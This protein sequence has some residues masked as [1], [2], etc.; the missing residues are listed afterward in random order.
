MPRG[1][2]NKPTGPGLWVYIHPICIMSEDSANY[3]VGTTSWF[4]QVGP[5][6][7]AVTARQIFGGEGENLIGKKVQM[8]KWHDPTVRM[9]STH[10]PSQFDVVGE[11]GE[12]IEVLDNGMVMFSV[13]SWVTN[14]P[15]F[16]NSGQWAQ[17]AVMN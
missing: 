1:V 11:V 14:L 12:I 15:G 8:V 17:L 4:L 10:D 9:V 7:R 6:W 5:E 16:I 3:R 13:Q 2:A